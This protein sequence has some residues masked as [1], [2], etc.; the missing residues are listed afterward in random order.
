MRLAS[1]NVVSAP[2][3]VRNYLA[4]VILTPKGYTI[5]RALGGDVDGI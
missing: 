1:Q 5:K 3:I 2:M 4:L